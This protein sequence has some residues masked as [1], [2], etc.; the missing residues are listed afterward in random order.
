MHARVPSILDEPIQH[1]E[2]LFV[3][4]AGTNFCIK[5]FTFLCNG[6]SKLNAEWLC[7]KLCSNGITINYEVGVIILPATPFCHP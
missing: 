2:G 5:R 1:E 3:Y 4:I 7:R 6:A